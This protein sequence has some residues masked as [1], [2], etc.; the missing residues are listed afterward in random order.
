MRASG[1]FKPAR[2]LTEVNRWVAAALAELGRTSEARAIMHRATEALRP[3]SFDEYARNRGRWLPEA[4]HERMLD[5]LRK[6]GWDG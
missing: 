1:L 2:T 6:A 5:G 4:V 3:T